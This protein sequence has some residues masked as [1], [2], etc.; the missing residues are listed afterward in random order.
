MKNLVVLIAIFLCFNLGYTQDD[1]R[2]L[3]RG[4]VIYRGTNVP[5][6]N[7]INIT[8]EDATITNENGEFA[9]RV[10]EGDELGFTAVN[11]QVRLIVITAEII[12]NNRLV[13]DVNEK[14]T[15][16]DEVVVSPENQE[17]FLALQKEKFKEYNYEADR[18]TE[19][20]NIAESQS[21]RGLQDGLNFVNIFKALVKSSRDKSGTT[22]KPLK[23]SEV[24]RQLYD[25]E[26][27][28][29][30]LK[31]PKDKIGAFLYYCD[32]LMPSQSLLK[33]DNEFELID[34]LVTHSK[35][36]LKNLDTEN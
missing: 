4:T 17:K 31:L 34:F 1:E 32:S 33:K 22:K 14:V 26:F 27:F 5:N 11:F 28:V 29:S 23:M 36:F 19:V 30:D 21:V 8:S 9:I 2:K 12:K 25:E 16:L 18:A 6:E 10:K 35:T 15:A 7:V 24:L 20:V 13:V 3:L